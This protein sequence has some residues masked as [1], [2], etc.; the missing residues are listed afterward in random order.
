MSRITNKVVLIT[1]A[2]SGIDE[3]TARLLAGEGARLMLGARRTDRLEKITAE[4]R[5]GGGAAEYHALDVTNLGDVQAFA[6]FGLKTFG[7]IDVM[8]NN[9][10]IM[11]LS[12]L[13]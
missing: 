5:A 10:G 11:P 9:A 7:Q 3:A 13:H 8:I 1:G 4:I 12:P 2:S 6:D